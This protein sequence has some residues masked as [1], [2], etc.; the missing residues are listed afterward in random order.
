MNYE[1]IVILP[2]DVEVLTYHNL[3]DVYSDLQTRNKIRACI[4]VSPKS[5][6]PFDQEDWIS[7]AARMSHFV[8]QGIK[9]IAISG[10]RGA[11]AWETTRLLMHVMWFAKQRKC[12]RHDDS[13]PQLAEPFSAMGELVRPD[14]PESYPVT[15]SKAFFEKLEV[16]VK[17]HTG[18]ELWHVRAKPCGRNAVFKKN[19]QRKCDEH[20]H[21]PRVPMYHHYQQRGRELHRGRGSSSPF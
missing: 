1:R 19:R 15:A 2:G 4:F 20:G 16:A 5:D 9:L 8:R 14:F 7:L 6:K 3:Y 11:R 12:N 13:V 10:L 21:R 17:P 18:T